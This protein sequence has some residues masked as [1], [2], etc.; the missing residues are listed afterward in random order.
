M[1][2]RLARGARTFR[3]SDDGGV[4]VYTALF[5]LAA[6]GVGALAI[7]IGRATVLNT[8]MQ[9]RADA[10]AMAGATQLDGRDG[11]QARA[12][13]MA[14]NATTAESTLAAD[15]AELGV[16]AVNF[17]TEIEP[18]LVP[19][20]GDADSWYVEVVLSPKRV[21]YVLSGLVNAGTATTSETFTASAIARPNPFICYAPPLMMCDPKESDPADD[22]ELAEN[23]GRQVLVKPTQG[24]G[25]WAPG[26]YGLLALPDGSSGAS[27]IETALAAV[28]PAECYSLDVETA[29]GVKTNKV[30]NGINA[31][32]DLPGVPG[33]PAP[34]VINYPTDPGLDGSTTE[35][36]GSGEWDREA[37]WTARHGTALPADL[38]GAS[39]YQTY[40]YELGEPYARNGRQTYYPLDADVPAGFETVTPPAANIPED[41]SDPDNP[42]VDGV[43]SQAVAA[44]G[45]ARRLVQVAV[46]Q[47]V[48]NNVQGAHTYPTNGNYVELFLTQAVPEEPEGAIYGEIVR[49][50]TPTNDPDF[51]SNVS[52]VR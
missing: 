5:M 3:R 34:N 35:N 16:A 31:R 12:R 40:L 25:S 24:G 8:Q 28:Q 32:F 19:A 2:E 26:N 27:A 39:R 46:I 42:D 36:M 33:D 52:L 4:L 22:L 48:A 44:N 9:N 29:P 15:G 11:A 30:Q 45:P 1:I 7:D 37:Y 6:V 51:H 18:D 43:P 20:T 14:L 50:L 17:Y 13:D 10:G 23:V 38:D 41:P 49:P 47:C 21:D